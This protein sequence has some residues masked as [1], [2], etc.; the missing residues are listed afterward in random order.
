MAL[1]AFDIY[2]S[3]DTA[4]V[5]LEP[6]IIHTLRGSVAFIYLCFHLIFLSLYYEKSRFPLVKTYYTTFFFICK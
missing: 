5:M 1:N 6:R 2:D 3:T 4:V